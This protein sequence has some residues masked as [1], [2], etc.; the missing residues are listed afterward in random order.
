[1]SPEGLCAECRSASTLG[2]SDSTTAALSP[3]VPDFTKTPHHP[4]RINSYQIR[5]VLGEGGMGIVYLAEQEQP[6][7]RLVALKVIK[8]G[9]DTEEVIARFES[10]RQAL[11]MMN[12]PHIARVLDA[13]TTGQG[14]PYFVMDYVP[15]IPICEY[16][17][18]QRLNTRERLDLFVMVCLAIQHAHQKGI[19]HRDIKPSNVLVSLEDGK[20]VPK[21]IDFGVAKAMNQRLTEK[22]LFTQQG[23]LVGTPAYM[24]PE[25][26]DLTGLDIDTTTD[27]YSLGVLLYE[28]LVGALPFDSGRLRRAGYDEIRRIIRDEDPL[29]PTKRLQ[30][31]GDTAIEVAKR[32]HTSLEVLK[33]QLR[34]DL[35][36]I[37][38]K[39][40]EKDRVRRYASASEFAADIHRYLT[41]E[42]IS[43]RPPSATYRIRKYIRRHKLGVAAAAFVVLAILIGTAGITIG[44]LRAV[45]AE[46]KA[47][48]EAATAKQVSD[49][50]VDLFKVSDPSNTKGNTITAREILD[51]GAKKVEEE[52]AGQTPIQA[53]LMETMGTVYRSLGLYPQAQSMLEKTLKLKRSLYG[54]DDLSVANTLHHLGI[55][56]DDQGKYEEAA[57]QFQKSLDIR[58]K[59]LKPD[60]P[61]VARSLNSLAIVFYNQGKNAEAEPLLERSLAIKEKAE[62]PDYVE[63]ANTLINLGIIKHAQRKYADAEAFFKRALTISEQKLGAENLDLA[64]TILNDIGSLYEDQG[65]RAEAEPLYLRSLAIWEKILGPDHPDVA[66]AVHNLANLYRNLGKYTQA[67]PLYLHSLAIWEKTLGSNHP[68]VGMSLRERANL[69]R[70]QGKYADAEPLYVRSLQIFEKSLD[71]NHLHVT[72][73]MENYILLLR[74]MNRAEEALKLDNRLKAIRSRQKK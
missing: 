50:L 33:R 22:T 21:V 29:T 5:K 35:D 43:A 62:R 7:R 27:I 2:T 61:E 9:M 63:V 55:V 32:R 3:A 49:F 71:E 47:V 45:R 41:E 66:I 37:T 67:E 65:R 40:M 17:D 59:R 10:E 18:R 19:I 42:P 46:K 53:R 56:Y 13:G 51:R 31:L 74:K 28:M 1:L 57:S 15:G 60:D 34:G 70:D 25:Q 72:D 23:V 26:A 39:A 38:M 12:H 54:S 6:I 69:Y 44:F 16:C 4:D 20:P 24:S 14:S 68:Y 36:W 11:A 30:S 58:S 73:T 8:L 48:E 64:A 52:L